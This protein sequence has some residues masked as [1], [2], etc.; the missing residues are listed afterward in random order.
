MQPAW[1][2]CLK[3]GAIEAGEEIKG[4]EKDQ[5]KSEGLKKE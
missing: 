4:R 5:S 2:A 3:E 1:L